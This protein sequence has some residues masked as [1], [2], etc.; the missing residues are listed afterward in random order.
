MDSVTM[1]GVAPTRW[2]E[3]RKRVGV[4]QRFSKIEKPS[5]THL[6]EAADELGLSANQFKR[7]MRSWRIHRDPTMLN[8]AGAPE[9]KRAHRKDGLDKS[10][11]GII[12][13]AISLHGAHEPLT[14]IAATVRAECERRMLKLPSNGAVWKA[15]QA[16]RRTAGPVMGGDQEILI[17]RVWADLP[18]AVGRDDES[19]QRPELLMA[20]Q[21]PERRIIGWACDLRTKSPPLLSDIPDLAT[22][23]DP[24]T[25]TR[26]DIGFPEHF[27]MAMDVNISDDANARFARMIGPSVGNIALGFRLPRTNA[28]RLL[29]NTLD[30]PLTPEDALLA[31][32]YAVEA[33]NQHVRAL[34]A[35]T[36]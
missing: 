10:V 12:K 30:A 16:A 9:S 5:A 13:A 26:L 20:L 15:V 25:V 27:E 2:N 7:L 23:G 28:A 11:L 19:L 29:T 3:I 35:P 22:N 32:E 31:I 36:N 33:H 24:L 34:S 4:L 14:V 8:G 6:Q 17:G 21:L 1:K 18:V